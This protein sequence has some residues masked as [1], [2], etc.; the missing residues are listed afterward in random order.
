MASLA[1]SD[2]V[3]LVAPRDEFTSTLGRILSTPD[4]PFIVDVDRDAARWIQPGAE[5]RIVR[6]GEEELDIYDGT[7]VNITE[8]QSSIQIVFGDVPGLRK[9]ERR[10]HTRVPMIQPLTWAEVD[11]DMQTGPTKPS[12]TLNLSR[13][14]VAFE[15]DGPKPLPAS[16]ISIYLALPTGEIDAMACTVNDESDQPIIRAEFL[17]FAD[18]SQARLYHFLSLYDA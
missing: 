12:R 11:D 15:A 7:V 5:V 2:R 6:Y 8:E 16:L 9:V 13:G 3:L 1:V 14:G 10:A 18:V 4:D 17:H